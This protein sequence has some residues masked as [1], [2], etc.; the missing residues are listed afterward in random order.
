MEK[1]PLILKIKKIKKYWS[2]NDNYTF[3]HTS[4]E[5]GN[6]INF[7][8]GYYG[9]S[10]TVNE[11]KENYG[12]DRIILQEYDFDKKEALIE[13]LGYNGWGFTNSDYYL[14]EIEV[15]ENYQE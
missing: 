12:Y 14:C 11:D 10:I 15:L 6:I 9:Y 13:V 5:E 1:K 7:G 4:I 8:Y 3:P 2:E